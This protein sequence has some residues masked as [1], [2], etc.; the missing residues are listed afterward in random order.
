MEPIEITYNQFLVGLVILLVIVIFGIFYIKKI[1]RKLFGS[2]I[3]EKEV[4]YVH[5]KW[6]EIENTLVLDSENAY[7]VAILE[8]D[9]LLDH[10][11]KSMQLPGENMGQRLKVAVARNQ[12][13]RPVWQ[14]H[15]VRNKIAHEVDYKV[16]KKNAMRSIKQ[17]RDTLKLL[18]Y[19]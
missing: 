15:I 11:F 14:A 2:R 7:K 8:A 6:E 10:V 13:V 5:K 9:K 17:F 19:L 16:T 12:K 1:I 4:K 3:D 18:G